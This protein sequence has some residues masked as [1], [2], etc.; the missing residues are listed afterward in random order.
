[1]EE[2]KP[3]I[4]VD[5]NWKEK[6]Q[7]EKETAQPQ[8]PESAKPSQPTAPDEPNV[9]P[10]ELDPP[11]PPASFSV[12]VTMLASQAMVAL[13]RMPDP[14]AGKV[15]VRHRLARHYIDTLSMLEEKTRGNL[16]PEETALLDAVLHDLRMSFVMNK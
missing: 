1:M 11:L 13:G 8:P 10:A 7:R 3:K 9:R 4:I 16:Q 12:L 5:E 14:V 15:V 2:G 6:V